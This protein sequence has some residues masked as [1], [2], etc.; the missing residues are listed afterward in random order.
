MASPPCDPVTDPK[1]I[2]ETYREK[3]FVSAIPVMTVEEASEYRRKLEAWE[4][5]LP[6]KRPV[7]NMRFKCHLLLTWVWEIIHN[8][9]ILDAVSAAGLGGTILLWNCEWNIKEPKSKGFFSWHQDSTYAGLE[10]IDEVITAWVALSP[11]TRES[12]AISFLPGTHHSQMPHKENPP[13]DNMLARGQEIISESLDESKAEIAELHPGQM[14]LHHFRAVHKSAPNGSDDRRIGLTLRF[15]S[16]RVAQETRKAVRESAT[17]CRGVY[18]PEE[19]FFDLEEPPETDMG[20]KEIM[21]QKAAM[22]RE[23][24]NYFEGFETKEYAR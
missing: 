24:Q 2:H 16:R 10:P 17:L 11:S 15:I 8:R 4:E 7:G 18:K 5:T 1:V 9:K 6:E 20:E 3:G 12:G 19:G 22:D 13:G 14:S 23:N 21:T